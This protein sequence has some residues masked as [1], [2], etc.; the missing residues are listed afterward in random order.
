MSK[1][2][3]DKDRLK[4]SRQRKLIRICKVPAIVLITET[5]FCSAADPFIGFVAEKVMVI[6]T[7]VLYARFKFFSIFS[8][9]DS[10]IFYK[11]ALEK[12]YDCKI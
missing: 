2:P 9:S 11:M 10:A 3:P 5:Y 7:N 8:Y 12:N 1:V 4:K 6:I